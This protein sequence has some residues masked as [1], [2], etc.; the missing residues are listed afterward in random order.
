MATSDVI[1]QPSALN[2]TQFTQEKQKAQKDAKRIAQAAGTGANPNSQLDKDAFMKLLLTE[3]Q[4]QDPTAPMDTEKMLTQT[5]QL[6]ALEMQENTNS[7]MK[8]LA[9]QLKSSANMFAVAALGK[10]ANRGTNEIKIDTAGENYQIPLYF[11]HPVKEGKVEIS[12]SAGKVLRTIELKD[13]MI[14]VEKIDFNGLD[15]KNNAIE[16][17]N[18]KVKATYIS[19]FGDRQFSTEYGN[20]PVES[21]KFVDGK[22][23]VKVA[24]EYVDIDTIS[25][26]F[27]G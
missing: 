7:T 1:N 3:L 15:D 21:V 4:Y 8:E 22:A 27:Q 16:P 10:M 18:Y 23:K 2:Y 5:S 6:A 24:G 9:S 20:Y 25:E 19:K 12:N 17:G 26:F 14:G 13:G 11:E